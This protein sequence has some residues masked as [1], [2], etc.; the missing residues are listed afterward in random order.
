MMQKKIVILL[1]MS[2]L[3]TVSCFAQKE[4]AD[5]KKGNEAYNE[6]HFTES[7]IAYRRGLS[8]N[9]ESFSANFNLGNALYRQG[10]YQD[11]VAQ[12]VKAGQLARKAEEK[13]KVSFSFHNIGNSLYKAGKYKEA[14]DAYKSSLKLNPND[15][16]TRYNY[17]L[18]KQKITQQ[19]QKQ[20]DKQQKS[21][22]QQS[23]QNQDK[24][25]NQQQND[26]QQQQM[27]KE[28]AEQLL[29]ALN[30]D[31]KET[32]K[33]VQKQQR[34]YNSVRTDKDW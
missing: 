29:D 14:L 3:G 30:Q 31:E 20:N 34:R 12:Y 25:Q 21:D 7:E 26:K 16:E 22:Q 27:S 8:K 6:K 33:R 23:Q 32:Q 17:A 24:Q 9:K 10:K 19:Q 11:A 2:T 18:T 28:Q 4:S 5:V 1:L 13:E 15:D